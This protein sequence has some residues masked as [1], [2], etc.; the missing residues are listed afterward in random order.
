[1]S[2]FKSSLIPISAAVIL[3][4]DSDNYIAA[5]IFFTLGLVKRVLENAKEKQEQR[6]R[7]E[8]QVRRVED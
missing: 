2:W 4:M 8:D 7:I 5:Q 3:A 1:M 6:E